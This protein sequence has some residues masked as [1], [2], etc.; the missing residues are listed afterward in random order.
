MSMQVA[1]MDQVGNH[2][3]AE[4][5]GFRARL[6]ARF[7]ALSKGG[8]EPLFTTDSPDLWDVYLAAFPEIGRQHHNCNACR[9]F[10]RRHGGLVTIGED[11][12][13]V[14]VMWDP[15][16]ATPENRG[17]IA[18]LARAVRSAPVSLAARSPCVCG[19]GHP[20]STT[21]WIGGIDEGDC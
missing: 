21:S 17:A 18:A 6:A 15:D 5:D 8:E 11:G 20:V 4:Y 7:K 2:S 1:V 12:A 3:D 14:P 9:D 10:I 13:T 19:L 16:D